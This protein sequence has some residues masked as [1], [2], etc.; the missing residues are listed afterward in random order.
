[1]P[2][3]SYNHWES[4]LPPAKENPVSISGKVE[5][6]IEIVGSCKLGELMDMLEGM[7]TK[8]V[9]YRDSVVTWTSY[10]G[11]PREPATLTLRIK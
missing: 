9:A 8:G 1:M 10:A 5:T 7:G 11:D 2:L 3:P 6:T 4:D